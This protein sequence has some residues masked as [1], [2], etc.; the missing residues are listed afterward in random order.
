M[1][2]IKT[3]FETIG[4]FYF[5]NL[6]FNKYA[7]FSGRAR[8]RELWWAYLWYS[9][10][11]LSMLLGWDSY[12]KSSNEA[13]FA[14][15]LAISIFVALISITPL[16]AL[17]IKR[18]HDVGLSGWWWLLTLLP[19]LGGVFLLIVLLLKGQPKAN[20][21]GPIPSLE[22]ETEEEKNFRE[23]LKKAHCGDRDAQYFIGWCYWRGE[24]VEKNKSEAKYWFEKASKQ[25]DFRATVILKYEAESTDAK[26]RYELLAAEQG[27]L[28]SMVGVAHDCFIQHHE[29]T[30]SEIT[31]KLVIN[32]KQAFS[33]IKKAAESNF[34]NAFSTIG[35]FYI[36]GFGVSKD[37]NEA[38][39]WY[40]K[41]A[42]Q[43]CESCCRSLG[44]IFNS[45]DYSCKDIL[46]SVKW[47]KKGAELGCEYS[48]FEYA[49]ALLN[50]DGCSKNE[51]EAYRWFLSA[52]SQNE[53]NSSKH[54]IC[55][56]N[57][58]DLESKLSRDEIQKAQ[59][60]AS[61]FQPHENESWSIDYLIPKP[62]KKNI[63][64][65]IIFFLFP[66]LI[67]FLSFLLSAFI[68]GF[69]G[70]FPD[71]DDKD[72]LNSQSSSNQLIS[73]TKWVPETPNLP[74]QKSTPTPEA[75]PTPFPFERKQKS[76]WDYENL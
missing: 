76:K 48:Q 35:L 58:A 50:G 23:T 16:I 47:F 21:W 54:E 11:Q 43:N 22:S 26:K 69:L 7:D 51:A 9:V 42:S 73:K 29:S 56:K 12:W 46:E 66:F 34:K 65:R 49:T 32:P 38:I 57:I 52:K 1:Q 40:K 60:L 74:K 68:I 24:G 15:A 19:I 2:Q 67:L 17:T 39:N 20:A 31:E 6:F 64:N 72:Q 75:A 18:F 28:R 53:L 13:E 45:F 25:G 30:D 59:S 5:L 71:S 63:I 41:G 3:F 44:M 14:A 55:V 37:I 61:H 36:E 62:P 27:D 10:F 4:L 8:R 33:L 70:K